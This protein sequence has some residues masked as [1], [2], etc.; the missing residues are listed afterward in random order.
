MPKKSPNIMEKKL[1]QR[2]DLGG[3]SLLSSG[4]LGSGKTSLTAHI[5]RTLMTMKEKD[6]SRPQQE[7]FF[8]RGRNVCQ[9]IKLQDKVPLQILKQEGTKIRFYGQDGYNFEPKE[10]GTFKDLYELSD[11]SKLTVLYMPTTRFIDFIRWIEEEVFDWTTFAIDECSDIAPYGASGGHYQ[12]CQEV[13]DI[14]K[15]TRK[16][17]ISIFANSQDFSDIQWFTLRKFMAYGFLE[18]SRPL[19]FSPVWKSAIRGL[20]LG[21]SWISMG[22][23]FQKVRF[24]PYKGPILRAKIKYN[25]G[26]KQ[27]VSEEKDEGSRWND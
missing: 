5:I 17:R 24:P 19:A 26:S 7:Q 8:W 22:N 9:W 4:I 15:E 11:P 18:G 14:L 6:E 1:L 25:S 23:Q 2:G 27:E 20:E 12:W 10:F 16:S 13:A 3:V 21:E